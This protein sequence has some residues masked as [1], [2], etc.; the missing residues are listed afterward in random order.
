MPTKEELNQKIDSLPETLREI[1]YSPE[2]LE[3]VEAITTAHHFSEEK[4]RLV[5]GALLRLFT[6]YL[7]PEDLAKKIANQLQINRQ[8]AEDVAKEIRIKILYP[9]ADELAQAHGFHIEGAPVPTQ[10]PAPQPIQATTVS[11]PTSPNVELGTPSPP[12]IIQQQEETVLK[13]RVQNEELPAEIPPSPLVLHQHEDV[14]AA[15]GT[16]HYAESLVRPSF[17]SPRTY[18]TRIGEY[19]EPM[20]TARLELGPQA[21]PAAHIEPRTTRVGKEEATVVHYSAPAGQ[22]NPFSRISETTIEPAPQPPAQPLKPN[23]PPSNVVNLKDL[24]K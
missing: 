15:Q 23:V 18:E 1:L 4:M 12:S 3:K 6:G 20:P 22:A 13:P 10:Q 16:N 14:E 24:P 8:I 9:V 21:E 11:P 2:L 5:A 19:A 7:H 17:Q